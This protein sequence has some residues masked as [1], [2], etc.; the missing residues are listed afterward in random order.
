VLLEALAIY[1]REFRGGRT[2][3]RDQPAAET[4]HRPVATEGEEEHERGSYAAAGVNVFCAETDE[5]AKKLFSSAQQSFARMVRGTRGKLPP[6]LTD[7]ETFWNPLEKQQA[8]A[9]LSRSFVGSQETV[10]AGLEQFVRET[11][12]DEVIVASAIYEH[13]A[14]LRSYELLA[15]VMSSG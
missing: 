15:D 10:R 14:R 4:G 3:K 1:R 7:I 5:E 9:M 8:S 6:P 12:V 2:D 11:G 13:S